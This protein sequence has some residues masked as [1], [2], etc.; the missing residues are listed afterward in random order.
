MSTEPRRL[1][2]VLQQALSQPLN[3]HMADQSR[4]PEVI[5]AVRYPVPGAA[6]GRPGEQAGSQESASGPLFA[7][8]AAM[9]ATALSVAFSAPA[10]LLASVAGLA[11]WAATPLLQRSF[12]HG[13]SGHPARAMAEKAAIAERDIDRNWELGEFSGQLATVFDALGDMVIACNLDG[14]IVYANETFRRVTGSDN[15]AGLTLAMT[16]IEPVENEA[17]G[18]RELV[19]GEG[20]D[21]TIWTWHETASRDPSSGDLFVNCIGRNV[22]AARK[23][24]AELVE[25]REKAEAASHAKSRFL[26]TV[27]HEIRTPLNGI[28]GMTHLLEQTETT[29]EQASYLKTARESGQSLLSLIEDLLDVTSIEAGRLHLRHE[30]GGLDE[31]VNGVCELMA[32]RAH[33]KGI[34]I[35]V[36]FAPDAPRRITSD[37]GRLRQVLFNLVGNAIK[38]TETGGVLIEVGRQDTQ[39]AFTVSDTGPGLKDADKDRIFNEFERADNG[40]TRKQGGAGLGLSI[41]ARIVAA[42]GGRIGV[43][44]TPGQGSI[45]QFTV[46]V[47]EL[48]EPEAGKPV[49][50]PLAD[51]TVLLIAPRGP[52]STALMWTI[53]DLGGIAEVADEPQTMMT[54][55]TR[56]FRSGATLSD[57]IV[58]RRLADRSEALLS[59]APAEFA[60]GIARTLV[61]A[62]EDSRDLDSHA[63]H[64]A[65]AWL[66][67]P[68]RRE[69]LVNVLTR[70]DDRDDRDRLSAKQRPAVLERSSDNPTLDILLAE[71]D[72]VNALVVRKMLA[73]Q[74]HR[75][76]VVD[77]GRDLVCEAME[78]PGGE[79]GY[80]LVITDLSMPELDGR[81]AIV[82]IRAEEAAG[83]LSRLPVIVLSAD[84][85]DS[86]RDDLLAAG[87]DGHAEKPVDPDW[88]LQL[89]TVTA[90][91]RSQAAG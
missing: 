32:S 67:R 90:R 39:L 84:G 27:S 72:P 4:A 12:K 52:V 41:S 18:A 24:E 26:A 28:L 51:R 54:A 20:A 16:G 50:G 13:A 2:D 11:V 61:I 46:P 31:L 21:Q 60:T 49:Q 37:I 63:G 33:E 19:L 42:L 70:R 15:P 65:D 1:Q 75:V 88:L 64:G 17:T 73:R 74:G 76:T 9:A 36:H 53:R 87:A 23:A 38:F 5:P 55:L 30:E 85:Q 81:S 58:D 43:T 29:P 7:V 66:V 80:D 40:P 48:A 62:P 78:R 79:A 77:N 89:A 68:V 47:R 91:K 35:A 59:A 86:I 8:S 82:K 6:T 14:R 44:S 83:Q 3:R 25:A 10:L 45:F 69:S 56:L 34:E 57:I 71:D 22:T